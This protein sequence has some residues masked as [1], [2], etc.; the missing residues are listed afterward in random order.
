MKLSKIVATVA[1]ATAALAGGSA[2]ATFITGGLSLAGGFELPAALTNFPGSMVSALSSF[3]IDNVVGNSF[4]VGP[5]PIFSA[6]SVT[7]M[8]FNALGGSQP[9]FTK[10][11]FLFTVNSFNPLVP[12]AMSCATAQCVDSVSFTAVGVVTAGLSFQP[13]GFTMVW[14]AQASC[15]ES[16]TLVGTCGDP[17]TA[18]WSASLSR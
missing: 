4:A 1:V 5:P 9:L 6:G 16:I 7:S 14:S 15:N 13:T 12:I 18:S 10:G 2:Q 3:N 11:L 8:D 17:A